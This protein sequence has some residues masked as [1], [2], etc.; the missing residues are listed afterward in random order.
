MKVAAL[1]RRLTGL[2]LGLY[3]FGVQ[4]QGSA[5]QFEPPSSPIVC[6]T[7]TQPQHRRPEFPEAGLKAAQIVVMR[8]RLRFVA[9]DQAPLFEVTYTNGDESFAAAVREFVANYRLPCLSPSAGP[10]EATQEFQFVSRGLEPI[11]VLTALRPKARTIND[12]D[13]ECLAPIRAAAPP[14]YPPDAGKRGEFGSV[15]VRMKFVSAEA[16]PEVT[17]LYD[18]GSRLFAN[19][20]KSAVGKYR[21][22][23]M[24]A[25]DA[26]LS[27]MQSF[28]FS[29]GDEESQL[30]P[31]VTFMQL[32]AMIKDVAAQ[33]VRFDFNTM[34]CPFDLKFS[35]YR[36]YAANR[37][38]ELTANDPNR[39]EFLE[40]LSSAT[41]DIPARAM[42]TVIGNSTTV[43]V[44]CA[45]LDL[46]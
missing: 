6:L 35:P 12:L 34:G 43:S 19:V 2:A 40:W 22:P 41:L 24:K 20:V 15:I 46:L 25:G 18:A 8:V 14:V 7:S 27:A 42:K 9:A 36:P 23:C 31:N 13:A 45:V 30:R 37:V 17:V 16:E 26:P 28:K 1:C 33:K 21:L 38:T 29:F 5:L 10:V 11:V 32:A 39:R 4:A 44:P 3:C